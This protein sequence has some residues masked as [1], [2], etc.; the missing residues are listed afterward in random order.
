MF[1]A[2]ICF[3]Y[4]R[5]GET[6]CSCG[7]IPQGITEEVKKQAEQ[8]INSRLIMYVP[9]IHTLA[10]NNTQSD[11]RYGNSADSQKLKKARAY[12][13]SAKKDNYGTIV[14]RYLED[15]QCQLRRFEQEHSQSDME[16]MTE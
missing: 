15:A 11:R 5:Q 14:E 12:L 8:R 4:Q 16:I 6:F 3:K 7:S 9:G 2:K 13:N 10:L 1:I